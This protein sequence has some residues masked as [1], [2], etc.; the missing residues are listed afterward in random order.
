MRASRIFHGHRPIELY[1]EWNG[2]TATELQK[3]TC[4]DAS[5]I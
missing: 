5:A 3:F 2:S 4:V 1:R